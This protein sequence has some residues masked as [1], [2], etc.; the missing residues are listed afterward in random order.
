ML[1]YATFIYAKDDIIK[2]LTIEQSQS[3]HDNLIE[4][5]YTHTTTID[6]CL[7]IEYLHNTC[8]SKIKE[9][10]SLSKKVG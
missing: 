9:I 4:D 1:P 6:A 10:K 7:W 3:E 2:A 8:K 5:G